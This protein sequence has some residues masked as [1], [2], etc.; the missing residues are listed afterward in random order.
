MLKMCYYTIIDKPTMEFKV[1]NRDYHPTA[2]G[3]NEVQVGKQYC[4]AC[5]AES[6]YN[7][8]TDWDCPSA[9]RS[10]LH[11]EVYTVIS[12]SPQHVFV[13]SFNNRFAIDRTDEDVFFVPVEQAGHELVFV[14]NELNSELAERTAEVDKL[15]S[16]LRAIRDIVAINEE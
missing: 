11:V 5:C 15:D 16:K 1:N 9:I 14:I 13:D 6:W 4:V 3:V 10:M 12:I 7:S 8:F 2:I